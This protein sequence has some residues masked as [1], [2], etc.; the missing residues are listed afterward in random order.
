MRK[1]TGT[2]QLAIVFLV[3]AISAASLAYALTTLWSAQVGVT[4]VDTVG[5]GVYADSAC[6]IPVQSID[7]GNQKK[8][9]Y[10]YKS[11]FVKNTGTANIALE[12]SSNAPTGILAGDDWV[13]KS[14]SSWASIRQYILRAGEILETKYEIFILPNAASGS[15]TWTL[16]LGQ[17]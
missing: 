5:L 7:F 12:Y 10:T 14:G 9:A 17:S 2:L 13:Y 3:A 8:G 6:T 11:L 16:N 1:S 4:V 15:M